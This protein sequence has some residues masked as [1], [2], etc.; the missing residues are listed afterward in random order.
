MGIRTKDIKKSATI[1]QFAQHVPLVLPPGNTTF[2]AAAVAA[3]SI[4]PPFAFTLAARAHG[5]ASAISFAVGGTATTF[6]SSF[7]LTLQ[8]IGRD[9]NHQPISEIVTLVGTGAA[10]A[11]TTNQFFSSLDSATVLSEVGD[12]STLTGPT[13]SIGCADGTSTRIPNPY[14]GVP[15]AN[16]TLIAAG[17][18]A[19]IA[20]TST[21]PHT[22]LVVP[23]TVAQVRLIFVGIFGQDPTSFL[24]L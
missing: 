16:L 13:F 4:N 5:G 10:T 20:A 21:A 3:A 17:G 19:L 9:E 18:A 23:N 8:L 7:S 2:F 1:A 6:T 15:A 12:V 14:R 24:E 22:A 11:V